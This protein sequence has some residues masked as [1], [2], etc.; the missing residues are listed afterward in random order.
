MTPV[1]APHLRSGFW[2]VTFFLSSFHKFSIA[3][4]APCQARHA[5]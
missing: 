3:G 4:F 5:L 1:L 2:D